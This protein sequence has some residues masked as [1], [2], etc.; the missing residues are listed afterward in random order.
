[1]VVLDI[2]SKATDLGS[3]GS[4]VMGTKSA[5][6]YG[7]LWTHSISLERLKIDTSYLLYIF[8]A[9]STSHRMANYP[10]VGLVRVTWPKFK[11]WDPSIN[12]ERAPI[13]VLSQIMLNF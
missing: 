12:S 4:K 3:T 13:F 7:N 5:F 11:I 10:H 8:R 6:Q 1:M 9:P 2:V